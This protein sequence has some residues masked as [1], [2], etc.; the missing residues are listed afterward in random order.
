[1]LSE[2]KVQSL[3][4]HSIH[5]LRILFSSE[6]SQCL[7]LSLVSSDPWWGGLVA[8]LCTILCDPIDC[9]PPGS[10]V[11]GI[12]QARI[13]G[14]PSPWDLH[15]PGIKSS[16]LDCRQ[17]LY[18]LSWTLICGLWNLVSWPGIEPRT[19]VWGGQSLI[20]WATREA[21]LWSTDLLFILSREE[22]FNFLLV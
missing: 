18:L 4:I 5:F 16:L 19:P 14:F 13:L 7:W 1:M 2:K 10:S 3:N 8:K 9:S 15:D 17:I 11:H 21:L 22:A 20:H 12:S 6:W